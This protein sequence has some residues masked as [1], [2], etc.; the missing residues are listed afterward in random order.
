[1]DAH[2][3]LPDAVSGAVGITGHSWDA[4]GI[5][6]VVSGA[7]GATGCFWDAV[8]RRPCG[9]MLAPLGRPLAP[10][11]FRSMLVPFGTLCH[12]FPQLFGPIGALTTILSGF[13]KFSIDFQCFHTKSSKNDAKMIQKVT[14][15]KQK[16][17][18]ATFPPRARSGTC[19]RHSDRYKF[20]RRRLP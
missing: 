7:T 16:L 2:G 17:P 8:R 5:L 20:K 19:R 12:S 6:D 13:S 15:R 14:Y 11:P 3:T 10:A 9:S 1:M 18:F 4:H